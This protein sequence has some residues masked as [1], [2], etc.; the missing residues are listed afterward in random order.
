[1]L[2]STLKNYWEEYPAGKVVLFSY[3]RPTLH[4]LRSRLAAEGIETVL[5]LGGMAESNRK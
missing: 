2:A 3:F 1:M 4:Y 5:L